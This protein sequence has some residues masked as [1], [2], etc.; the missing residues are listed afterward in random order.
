MAR[1]EAIARKTLYNQNSDVC[2]KLESVITSN[3]DLGHTNKGMKH[4]K[5]LKFN[6]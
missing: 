2:F 4:C 1:Y 6:K 5:L 3:Q